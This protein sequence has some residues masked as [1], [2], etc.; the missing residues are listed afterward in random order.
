[1]SLFIW[2]QSGYNSH[3]KVPQKTLP[4]LGPKPVFRRA[5]IRRIPGGYPADIRRISG[6]RRS[7]PDGFSVTSR[8]RARASLSPLVGTGRRV[9]TA[10]L[11][12]PA[13]ARRHSPPCSNQWR[14]RCARD[15]TENPSGGLLRRADIRRISAGYPPDIR[16]VS[17]GYPPDIR[18][19]ENGFWALSIQSPIFWTKIIPQKPQP[20]CCLL[21]FWHFL[22]QRSLGSDLG[23]SNLG[24]KP[25]PS[26][27]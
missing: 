27:T 2:I 21:R 10:G 24:S 4:P 23:P 6:L 11:V 1:M 16:R 9:A 26:A 18:P 13:P 7:P 17:A 8:M 12:V 5:D 20:R 15:V 3:S 25:L 19:P 14:E 22:I